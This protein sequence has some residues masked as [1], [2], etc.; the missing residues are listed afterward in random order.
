MIHSLKNHPWFYPSLTLGGVILILLGLYH[1]TAFDAVNAWMSSETYKHCFLI[2]PISIYLLWEKR[3]EFAHVTPRPFYP[4]LSLYLGIIPAFLFAHIASINVGEQLML[5]AMIQTAILSILG[6][7]I[8][9]KFLFPFLYLWLMVP[10]GE[11]LV[12]YLQEITSVLA[13]ALLNL[14][15]VP[16][17]SDGIFISIPTGDFQVAEACAGIRFLIANVTLGLLFAYLFYQSF[18]RRIVFFML[19][20]IVPI[21]A[22]GIR[23]F[24]IIFIAYKTN[25]EYAVGVDHLV[26]GWFFF[27]FVL[28]LLIG[29]GLL[30]R[31]DIAHQPQVSQSVQ[32]NITPNISL[33]S[34]II[35][36]ILSVA[37]ISV[38]PLWRLYHSTETPDY[39]REAFKAPS[40]KAPW[41]K[42]D[43]RSDWR[44]QYETASDIVHQVYIKEGRT[45]ELFIAFYPVQK[46]GAEVVS[47]NNKLSDGEI[48]ER[49]GDFS[50]KLKIEGEIYPVGGSLLWS[51]HKKRVVLYWNRINDGY[52]SGKL[53]SKLEQVKATFLT[54]YQSAAFIGIMTDVVEDQSQAIAL[55]QDFTDHLD[56]ISEMLKKTAEEAEK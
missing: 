6:L 40:I 28:L 52:V 39:Q 45:V 1:E 27:L 46:E 18:L 24:G 29:I 41:K 21:I 26:Y 3:S 54:H 48:W 49:S 8:Y 10:I 25:N 2:L 31:E 13:V 15:G 55:L 37:L 38:A 42:T 14:S 30:F 50:T 5:M 34:L 47:Y 43:T 7:H 32:K 12:P 11:F 9:F 36:G 23:A 51:R 17:Y 33:S 56:P 16:N 4:A 20:I 44:P 19:S 22:N 53:R 35:I